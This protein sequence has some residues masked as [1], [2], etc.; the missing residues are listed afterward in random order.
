MPATAPGGPAASGATGGQLVS[1][2]PTSSR[3][4]P[5]PSGPRAGPRAPWPAATRPPPRTRPRSRERSASPSR[6][7]QRRRI[8]R[9][10][11]SPRRTEMERSGPESP[12]PRL[13][14][15]PLLRPRPRPRP[16]QHPS[17]RRSRRYRLPPIFP[18]HPR[19]SGPSL[20]TTLPAGR[21]PRRRHRHQLPTTCPEACRRLLRMP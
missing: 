5:I 2:R 6:P 16:H 1:S 18:E 14:A 9:Q 8:T 21:R 4:S 10:P 19:L 12:R 20:P 7:T 3:S 11:R 17:L 15:R 13:S